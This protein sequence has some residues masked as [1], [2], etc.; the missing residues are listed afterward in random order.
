MH[1]G[2]DRKTEGGRKAEAGR[3]A[4]LV[5]LT[6]YADVCALYGSSRWEAQQRQSGHL[7]A[8]FSM[9]TETT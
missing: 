7:R 1:R 9:V 2:V 4:G 6:G 5:P 8:V 3:Q